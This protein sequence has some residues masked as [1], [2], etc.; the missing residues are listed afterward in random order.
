MPIYIS[1]R[2]ST[3]AISLYGIINYIYTSLKDVNTFQNQKKRILFF[4]RGEG[5][6]TY[7]VQEENV[8]N[9][10][11]CCQFPISTVIYYTHKFLFYQSPVGFLLVL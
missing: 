7:S 5:I 10:P 3:L 1:S 9:N 2:F 4:G 11:I 6:F 8:L